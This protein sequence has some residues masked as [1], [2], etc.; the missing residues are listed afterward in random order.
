MYYFHSAMSEKALFLFLSLL[1]LFRLRNV[2]YWY[3]I[4][5]RSLL[6]N[7]YFDLIKRRSRR[8]VFHCF[9]VRYH[10]GWEDQYPHLISFRTC[11]RHFPC[12]VPI[13]WNR[14]IMRT[15][16]KK[17]A[18]IVYYRVI[19]IIDSVKPEQ[20]VFH[21]FDKPMEPCL[22]QGSKKMRTEKE[23]RWQCTISFPQKYY[24]LSVCPRNVLFPFRYGAEVLFLFHDHWKST[25]SFPDEY[26]PPIQTARRSTISFPNRWK[27]Y[28]FSAWIVQ[29]AGI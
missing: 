13:A 11:S 21:I 8:T 26:M 2:T 24:F 29:A 14:V 5:C 1:F 25:I 19:P 20:M 16:R 6:M 4:I 27:Y 18:H 28:F 17:T 22:L 10:L 7:C 15:L 9:P 12:I 3:I 23:C